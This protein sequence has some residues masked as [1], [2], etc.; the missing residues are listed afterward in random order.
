M[1][2]RKV[3]YAEDAGSRLLLNVGT[4]LS[5]YIS[6]PRI[7]CSVCYVVQGSFVLCDTQYFFLFKNRY[8]NGMFRGISVFF[9]LLS[10]S[11]FIVFII[12][13]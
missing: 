3:L 8:L 13:M 11:V 7:T 6:H 1:F 9:N 2:Y 4:P 12:Y 5:K 10:V